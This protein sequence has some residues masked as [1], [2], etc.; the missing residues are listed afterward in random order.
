METKETMR[1]LSLDEME[2]VNGGIGNTE[3]R[4]DPNKPRLVISFPKETGKQSNYP[5]FRPDR[6]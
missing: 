1:E 2:Q 3:S 4:T 6:P 5:I